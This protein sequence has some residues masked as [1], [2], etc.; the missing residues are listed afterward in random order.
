MPSRLTPQKFIQRAKEIHKEDNYDYSEIKYVHSQEKIPIICK[1][2]G[3]YFQSPQKHLSGQGCPKCRFEKSASK[4][5]TPVNKFIEKAI[6]IHGDKYKYDKVIYKNNSTK[7]IITCS[8]HGDFEMTPGNHTHKTTPQ[9]CPECG[10]RTNWN[11][12][13]FIN[14]AKKNHADRYSYFKI[15]F[16]TINDPVIIICREHGDFTQK[17]SKHLAGQG[18]PVCSGTKK[19]TTDQFI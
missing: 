7:V 17:P 2:H 4:Q 9:G 11:K 3:K 1:I 16:N 19:K 5:R 12:E 10:G 15:K 18:C 8:I 13:K 6:S 14:E